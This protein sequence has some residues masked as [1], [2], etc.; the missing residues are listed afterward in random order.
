MS[1]FQSSVIPQLPT[2]GSNKQ[3]P[4]N[5]RFILALPYFC[6]QI[7]DASNNSFMVRWSI[8]TQCDHPNRPPDII[9]L[10]LDD[11]SK[12]FGYGE[13]TLRRSQ[14]NSQHTQRRQSQIHK[15]FQEQ[16]WQQ[17]VASEIFH[18][19]CLTKWNNGNNEKSSLLQ[20]CIL[21]DQLYECYA[22]FQVYNIQYNMLYIFLFE[23][24][25]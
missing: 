20:Y 14:S 15:I 6:E 11:T 13:S 1:D 22:N 19:Q 3:Y 16:Y 12:I 2:D 24:C 5:D 4:R 7:S 9:L 18:I 23:F 8:I 17:Y 10:G 25:F 21:A